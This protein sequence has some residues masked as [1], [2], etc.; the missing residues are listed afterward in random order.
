MRVEIA[1]L[2]GELRAHDIPR[3][4]TDIQELRQS[5]SE[6]KILSKEVRNLHEDVRAIKR[7]S[8]WLLIAMAAAGAGIDRVVDVIWSSGIVP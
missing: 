4:A 1:E 5:I 6:I 2:R 7:V 3:M 8:F